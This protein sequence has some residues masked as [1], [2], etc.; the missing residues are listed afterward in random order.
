M[1]IK[2]TQLYDWDI[3]PVDERPSEFMTSTSWS[4]L[5]G[6]HV[7]PPVVQRPAAPR[8]GFTRLLIAALLLLALG[9]FAITKIAPLLRA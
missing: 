5:S 2:S 8:V 7:A 1:K 4:S 3:E 9:A 6:F